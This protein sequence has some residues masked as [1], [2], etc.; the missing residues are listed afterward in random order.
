MPLA[1]LLSAEFQAHL[2]T[3]QT[4]IS[5]IVKTEAGEAAA[6][7][8]GP[9]ARL[10]AVKQTVDT[11]ITNKQ[12]A[13]VLGNNARATLVLFVWQAWFTAMAA[14]ARLAWGGGC[15]LFDLFAFTQLVSAVSGSRTRRACC[16][17]Q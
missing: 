2:T 7:I 13:A 14:A 5:G 9:Q 11:W 15:A 3:Q 17:K 16:S 4:T 12:L 1:R 10:A 8:A 6:T